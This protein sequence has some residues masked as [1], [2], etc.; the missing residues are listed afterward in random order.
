MDN[1]Q[2]WTP[3]DG[4]GL[5]GRIGYTPSS[6]IPAM[7]GGV[8]GY[9]ENVSL[10]QIGEN[11]TMFDVGSD[12]TVYNPFSTAISG[13]VHILCKRVDGAW[14]VDS[15]H[16]TRTYLLMTPSGGIPARSGTT[17]GSANCTPYYIESS[18]GS[19]I[20]WLDSSAASQTF[21]VFNVAASAVAG[22]KYIQAKVVGSVLV[23]DMEDCG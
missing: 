10:Y 15:E 4:L 3:T 12:F 18:T 6:G 13:N 8:A 11:G 17:A 5:E 21:E 14:I 22:D 7:D 1:E 16:A 23:V 19:I 2:L 20:E 9:V